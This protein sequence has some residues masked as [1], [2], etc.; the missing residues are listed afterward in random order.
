MWC[1]HVKPY[2]LYTNKQLQTNLQRQQSPFRQHSTPQMAG[3]AHPYS[4]TCG[5]PSQNEGYT[6]YTQTHIVTHMCTSTHTHTHTSMCPKTILPSPGLTSLSLLHIYPHPPRTHTHTLSLSLTHT[7]TQ[8]PGT[9]R[10][11][12]FRIQRSHLP[13]AIR[14]GAG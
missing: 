2:P 12:P 8:F 1:F 9:K 7:H 6:V 4:S 14:Q 10:S 11:H 5:D 13:Y 3:Q